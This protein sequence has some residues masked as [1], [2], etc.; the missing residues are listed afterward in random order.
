MEVDKALPPKRGFVILQGLDHGAH[1]AVEH[2]NALAG[3][4]E[5]GGTLWRNR[6]THL[7]KRPS[8]RHWDG[9]PANG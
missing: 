5:Q 4:G 6:N 8:V 1:G 7:I 9:C 3:G 2:Q